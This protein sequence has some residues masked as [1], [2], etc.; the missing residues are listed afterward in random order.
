MLGLPS[1][2]YR[3]TSP[4]PTRMLRRTNYA[5]FIQDDWKVTPRLTVN[6]GLRYENIRPWVDKYNQQINADVFTPGVTTAPAPRFTTPVSTIV[7]NSPSP[8]LTRPGSGDFYQGLGFRY[9]TGQPVQGG[10]QFMGRALVNP[11]NT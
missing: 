11:N 5:V 2:A 8:I 1:Q 3:V 4:W 7:P 9:A 6:L 10:N